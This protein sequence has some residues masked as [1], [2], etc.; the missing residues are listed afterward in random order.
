MAL[1]IFESA[2]K[3]AWAGRD[4]V[5]EALNAQVHELGAKLDATSGSLRAVS[6]E[7]RGDAIAASVA[8]V[9]D[10]TQSAVERAARYLR[11]SD[12]ERIAVDLEAFSRSRPVTA[13]LIA[14][15]V[16]FSVSR[17]VKASSAR[18]S[19]ASGLQTS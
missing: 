5:V 13:T 14:T 8:P 19:D 9:V 12:V 7:L 18:R 3:S 17:A 15:V 2:R 10:Q 16:G 6:T 4:F 11:E 1:K